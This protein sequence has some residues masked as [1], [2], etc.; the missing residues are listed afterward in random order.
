MTTLPARLAALWALA[1]AVLA[2]CATPPHRYAWQPPATVS[3]EARRACHGRADHAA[4]QRY[5]QYWDTIE[6]IG[7]FGGPFGGT[8]LA[9]RAYEEREEFYAEE[10]MAC[11][12]ERG[13]T[14]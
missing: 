10:M 9:Q 1:V 13:Y 2:A 12:R 8:T 6:L 5:D 3:A 11:L 4:Q 14:F 7:P